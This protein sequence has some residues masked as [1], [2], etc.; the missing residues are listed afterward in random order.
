MKMQDFFIC[1]LNCGGAH[2][3]LLVP[4]MLLGLMTLS[5]FRTFLSRR[6]DLTVRVVYSSVMQVT[7]STMHIRNLHELLECCSFNSMHCTGYVEKG[8]IQSGNWKMLCTL[9]SVHV[10]VMHIPF[11]HCRMTFE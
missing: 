4:A 3:T 6:M 7:A 10:S 8:T 5:M 2:W 1:S 9:Y 11:N